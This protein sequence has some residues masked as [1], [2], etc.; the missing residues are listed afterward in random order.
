MRLLSRLFGEKGNDLRLTRP[1]FD[2]F[3]HLELDFSGTKLRFKDAEHTAMFPI[4]DWPEDM[5]I[6]NTDVFEKQKD[7]YYAKRFYVRGWSFYGERKDKARGGVTVSSFV[8]YFPETYSDNTDCFQLGDFEHEILR[9]C[10]RAWGWQNPGSS[11]GNLGSEI[12][13]VYPIESSDL[14]YQRINGIHWCRFTAQEKGRAPEISYACPIS[15]RHI[16]I[17]SFQLSAYDG[18]DYYSPETNLEQTCTDIVNEYMAEF[19]I[20]LSERAQQERAQ[21]SDPV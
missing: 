2:R 14:S 4:N 13:Y 12:Y 18:V 10:N 21:V 9:Y 3:G 15:R 5:N 7:G 19:T 16:I 20:K 1:E 11:L 17:N 6:Y 8:F